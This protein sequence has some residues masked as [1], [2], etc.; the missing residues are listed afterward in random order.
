MKYDFDKV[1]DR[2]GT[3]AFKTDALKDKFGKAGLALNDG[4]TFNP[5]GEG[6]MRLNVAV[7]RTV[8]A[9][10]MQQLLEVI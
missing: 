9:K 3:G 10:A 8:L 1:I 6:F 4:E 7:P 5:G 2:R